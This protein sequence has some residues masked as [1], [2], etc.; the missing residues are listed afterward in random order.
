[1]DHTWHFRTHKFIPQNQQNS[2][3]FYTGN[4]IFTGSFHGL[5]DQDLILDPDWLRVCE[6]R[7]N[8]FIYTK[9]SHT[10][11]CNVQSRTVCMCSTLY[12]AAML[13]AFLDIAT[14]CENPVVYG[15]CSMGTASFIRLLVKMIAPSKNCTVGVIRIWKTDACNW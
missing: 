7:G 4:F 10:V 9:T 8:E 2:N 11:H 3:Y 5:M 14:I 15:L 13:G 12:T 6:T 1:M